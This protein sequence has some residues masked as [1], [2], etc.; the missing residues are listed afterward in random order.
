MKFKSPILTQVSGSIGGA[1]YSHNRGG[2]YVRARAIPTDPGSSFQIAVRNAMSTLTTRW[3]STLT[4]ANRAAWD[5]Y[6]LNTPVTDK[7]GDS[8]LLSGQQHF[9]RSNLPRLQAGASI[10]DAGP[11]TYGLG[12]LN[13]V[14]LTATESSP[15]YSLAYDDTEA[16]CD[17]DDSHMLMYVSRPVSPTVNYFKGPFR[18]VAKEDGDSVTPPTSPFTTLLVPFTFVEDMVEFTRV[19]VSRADGRLSPSQIVSDVTGS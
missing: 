3:K 19:Q 6:A 13:A 17:E 1:T 8:I 2:L 16:W 9:I 12:S 11:T 7:F 14:T 4:A 10:V 18:F 15:I 5:T